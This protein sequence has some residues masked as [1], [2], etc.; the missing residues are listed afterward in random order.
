[1]TTIVSH[2][3]CRGH[4]PENTLRGMRRA[5]S[6]KA[7]AIEI[8]VRRCRTGEVVLMHDKTLERTTNGEGYVA[9]HSFTY[10]ARLN[11]GTREAVPTLEQALA[12][13]RDRA[14]LVIEIK[15]DRA[16]ADVA[17]IV[18]AAIRVKRA[19]YQRIIVSSFSRTALRL[20]REQ[21][22]RVKLSLVSVRAPRGL[23]QLHADIKLHSVCLRHA[24]VDRA[25]LDQAR[26][27]GLQVFAW[28]VNEQKEIARM[29]EFDVDG[30]ISDY[31]DRVRVQ[32][33]HPARR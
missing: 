13:V 9:R 2:R 17:R 21:D 14:T 29:V 8:D 11:A 26:S 22:R 27:L 31:P 7:D 1:M 5:L 32:V 30:I 23:V 18:K 25:V 20:V 12:L 19:S 28:T 10:I 15:D 3:A 33:G 6:M 24:S 4:E 16:S